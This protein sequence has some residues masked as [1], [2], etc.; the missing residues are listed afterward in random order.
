MAFGKITIATESGEWEEN[1]LTRP[2]TS[3]GRQ[4]GNDIVIN[5]S[6]VS[7]YHAQFDVYGGQVFL[8]DL[9]TVNGTYINDQ[10]VEP[11]SRSLLKD[12]D[13]VILGDVRLIFNATAKSRPTGTGLLALNP[14]V[15]EDP[16]V[17]IRLTLDDPGLPVAPG[18]FLQLALII[19][20]H[21]GVER[22]FTIQTDG[23]Q[24]DWLKINRREVRLE[25][26]EQT[27]VM[28]S[29]RPPRMSDTR[30]SHYTL[31][32]RVAYK[33]DPAQM[34]EVYREI[35]VIGFTGLAM[36]MRAGQSGHYSLAV[37]NQGNHPLEISLAGFQHEEL[38]AFQFEPDHMWIEAGD[39][40]QV[41]L[42]VKAT[43]PVS[44][45][46]MFAVVARSG[47]EA[48]FQAPLAAVYDTSRVAARSQASRRNTAL[49]F[50][51]PVLLLM[52]FVLVLVALGGLWAV[53]VIK[54]PLDIFGFGATPTEEFV[55][56]TASPP[57]PSET[58]A[59]TAIPT[60]PIEL[61]DFNAD[62]KEFMFGTVETVTFAWNV[63]DRDAAKAYSLFDTETGQKIEIS[64][65]DWL[66]G[67]V[68]VKAESLATN[69]GWDQRNY[70]L[71]VIGIDDKPYE[72]QTTVKI[73][74]SKCELLTGSVLTLESGPR[75]TA[76]RIEQYPKEV[77]VGGR[78]ENP[79]LVYLWSFAYHI[80]LGYT[81]LSSVSCPLELKLDEFIIKP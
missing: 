8:V 28:I 26:D 31:A 44:G 25:N 75:D 66:N 35:E 32:I 39:T 52:G 48:A 57:P 71:H 14:Q 67:E 5:S 79:P 65:A 43:R 73:N 40:A 77:V 7:R 42:R 21:S 11:N 38:L 1:E 68:V 33:D 55:F 29:I 13:V 63:N 60:P 64:P 72:K 56:K 4:S 47:D 6:A 54:I 34:I 58:P 22:L 27:E 24:A 78:A 70:T 19:E 18:A 16:N 74:Y 51:I 37:Q 9:G 61:S 59:P 46:S 2:T 49:G 15:H 53:G 69:Y 62:P 20:N 80:A 23:M 81:D 30:P 45:P 10:Q 50:G 41:R 76:T 3:V 17:P 36:A 12:G